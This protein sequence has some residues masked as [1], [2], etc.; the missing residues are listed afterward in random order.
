LVHITAIYAADY[1]GL[2][3]STAPNLV[4]Q[5]LRQRLILWDDAC[6]DRLKFISCVQPRAILNIT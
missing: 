6:G 3:Q 1:R 5:L 2:C 4:L